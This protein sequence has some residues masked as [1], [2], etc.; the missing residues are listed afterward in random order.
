MNLQAMT[1]DDI[2]LL[3]HFHQSVRDEFAQKIKAAQN[4][5]PADVFR[6]ACDLYNLESPH[7]DTLT[8][9]PIK[10]TVN[11]EGDIDTTEYVRDIHH[12]QVL[13]LAMRAAVQYHA[14][15]LFM[16]GWMMFTGRGCDQ[17][18]TFATKLLNLAV[19]NGSRQAFDYLKQIKEPRSHAVC[20]DAKPTIFRTE[21]QLRTNPRRRTLEFMLKNEI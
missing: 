3:R 2:P 15:A 20:Y 19:E 5:T 21:E 18:R 4:G 12:A 17:N 14:P 8:M 16:A 6:L 13:S 9:T 11:N 7:N 10:V 1:A